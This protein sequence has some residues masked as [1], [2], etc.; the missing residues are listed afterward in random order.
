MADRTDAGELGIRTG[1]GGGRLK[2]LRLRFPRLGDR[3]AG[4]G[5]TALVLHVPG[6]ETSPVH[7]STR[8]RGRPGSVSGQEKGQVCD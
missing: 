8:P 2:L 6:V 7:H 1:R 3:G 5:T 4:P